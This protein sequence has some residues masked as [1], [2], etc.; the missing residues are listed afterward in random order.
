MSATGAALRSPAIRG[1]GQRLAAIAG[2]LDLFLLLVQK[3]LKVKYKGT[4]LGV[5]WSLLNPL[6]MMLVYTAIFTVIARANIPRYQVYVFCAL[7]PWTAFTAAVTSGTTSVVNNG[8]LV[9]RVAFPAELFPLTSVVANLIN[10]LPGFLILAA[11]AL[12]LHQPFGIALVI[13]PVLIVLQAAFSLGLVLLLSSLNVYFRDVEY[14]IGVLLTVWFFGTPILYPLTLFT[15]HQRIRALIQANPMTWLMD[16][17]QRIW[18][19]ATWP[20]WAT[21]G[22]FALLSVALVVL[23]ALAFGRASRRFAEEV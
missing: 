15:H 21:L 23:G 19:S 10:A 14:L 6:F 17:Y 22:A 5:L 9:R 11:I 7:L 4:A 13:L 3:E 8:N 16:A 1:A 12:I 2:H 20:E 18:Y